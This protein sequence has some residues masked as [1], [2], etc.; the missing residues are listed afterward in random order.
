MRLYC[1][2]SAF[3][4]A[5]GALVSGPVE[6]LGDDYS[7]SEGPLWLPGSGWV[8]SD[9]AANIIYRVDGSVLRSDS[10]G[11]NGLAVDAQGRL[12]C[13]EG[14]ARRVTRLEEDGAVTVLADSY[15]GERLNAPND[16]VVRSDGVVFFTDPES[17]RKDDPKDLGFSGVYALALDGTL[18]LL[19]DDIKYPNGI[20]LSPDEKTLYV[21]DTRGANIRAFDLEG[22]RAV[23]GRV[24]CDVRIPDGMA[25][26]PKGNVWSAAAGGIAVFDSSGEPLDKIKIPVMPTNCAFGGK[27]GKTLFVTARKKVFS[28]RTALQE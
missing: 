7:F 3:I 26:D 12:I 23:R 1:I 22:V 13:C 17:L 20:G 9:V 19:I 5:Q 2:V 8:F 18:T 21:S 10:G 14:A 15:E 16:L 6:T 27:D 28:L 25:V 11:A 24:F 4:L